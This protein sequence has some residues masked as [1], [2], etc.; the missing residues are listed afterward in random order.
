[1]KWT[2]IR[3][4]TGDDDTDVKQNTERSEPNEYSGYGDID[5]SHVPTKAAGEEK[6]GGLEHHRETLD[7]QVERPF[8]EPIAFELAVSATLDR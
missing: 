5:G 6:E 1:L 4:C 8:P 2:S 7:E 3:I